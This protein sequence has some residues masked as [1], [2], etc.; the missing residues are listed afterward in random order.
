VEATAPEVRVRPLAPDD[1]EWE[2][3]TILAAWGSTIA[4]RRGEPLELVGLPGLVAELDGAR[5]G[6]L[7]YR[8]DDGEC[9]VASLNSLME[10][11]GVGGALLDAVVEVA[12][13]AGCGGLWLATTNDNLRALRLYQRRGWRLVA[14][15]P[16]AV[17]AARRLKPGIPEIG[18]E[19]IPLRDELELELRL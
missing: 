10:G 14:L 8:V 6:L 11:R 19:G 7:T 3:Q 9:E 18:L 13:A 4:I 15:R 1:E 16:G 12:R 17:I 5:A 2:R